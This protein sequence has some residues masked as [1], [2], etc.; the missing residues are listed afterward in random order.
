[1]QSQNKFFDDMA[2]VLN[3]AAGTFAGMAREAQGVARDKAREFVG[4]DE[5][6]REE[7]DALKDMLASARGE[8]AALRTR[9]DVM[10]ASRVA[11]ASSAP[12]KGKSA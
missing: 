3:G 5:I 2:K 11:P 8:I 9:I 7:F 12:K 4:A 1:M 6:S 10:E